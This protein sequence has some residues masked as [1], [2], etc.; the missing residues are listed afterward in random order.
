MDLDR[1]FLAI[2]VLDHKLRAELLLQNELG[3]DQQ[4]IGVPEGH[5]HIPVGSPSDLPN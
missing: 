5:V 1:N 2:A 4:A 3:D